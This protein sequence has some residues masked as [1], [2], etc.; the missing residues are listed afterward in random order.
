M[1]NISAKIIA[2]SIGYN[3]CRLTTFELVYPRFVLAELNTHRAFSRNSASSRAIPISKVISDVIKN[4]A[5]PVYWGENKKGMQA[6]AELSGFRKALS[7]FL[8]M[9][10]R[11]VACGIAYLFSLIGLHKQVSNRILEPWFMMRTVLSG[12]DFKNFF[13]LRCHPDAQ[14]EIRVL[15]EKMRNAYEA[16]IPVRKRTGEYHLPYGD[17][18]NDDELFAVASRRKEFAEKAFVSMEELRAR[19]CIARCARVSYVTH[20]SSRINYDADLELCERLFGSYP[21]HLSPTEH[22]AVSMPSLEYSGNF[23]GWLQFRKR[24]PDENS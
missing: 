16:S 8:W 15:A 6:S 2:D 24:F 4:P 22:V 11:Y 10:F 5:I 14:P 20:G 12:T 7:I 3:G 17:N 13:A 23:H 21:R 1:N 18:I 9:K 19:V